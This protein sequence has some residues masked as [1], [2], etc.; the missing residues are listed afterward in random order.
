MKAER[1]TLV[2]PADS[3]ALAPE[4]S[5]AARPWA[6]YPAL[7]GTLRIARTPARDAALEALSGAY[8]RSLDDRRRAALRD[9]FRRR[10]AVP[11]VPFR[12]Q[13]RACPGGR[14]FS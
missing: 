4:E 10:L 1:R 8:C 11:D 6:S 3:L 12:Q 13:S 9:E 7:S 14:G 5:A 2:R